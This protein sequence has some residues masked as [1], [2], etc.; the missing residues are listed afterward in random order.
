MTWWELMAV[1]SLLS[2]SSCCSVDSPYHPKCFL[3]IH[4]NSQS[5]C[6]HCFTHFRLMVCH[7]Q[8]TA[9]IQNFIFDV[10]LTKMLLMSIRVRYIEERKMD[11]M[12]LEIV[13]IGVANTWS[14]ETLGS[15]WTVLLAFVSSAVAADCTFAISTHLLK[16]LAVQVRNWSQAF[17]E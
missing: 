17:P 15:F 1:L 9:L 5:S 14:R 6:N 8:V 13:G 12:V 2:L 7:W 16:V 10:V 11:L 4:L 3:V